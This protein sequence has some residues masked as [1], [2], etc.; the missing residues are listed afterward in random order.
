MSGLERERPVF[1][2]PSLCQSIPLILVL[3]I[4]E[5]PRASELRTSFRR[6]RTSYFHT[7]CALTHNSH[8]SFVISETLDQLTPRCNYYSWF[9]IYSFSL[10]LPLSA[11]EGNPF[12]LQ[13]ADL[14]LI[15]S[16]S[17]SRVFFLHFFVLSLDKTALLARPF[18][19]FIPGP[20]THARTHAVSRFQWGWWQ[21]ASWLAKLLARFFSVSG[22]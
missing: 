7:G 8:I 4:T 13:A 10:S 2:S 22:S 9:G 1:P 18:Y 17:R 20:A 15:L 3:T 11:D 21:L 6:R 5:T 16:G 19:S 14:A 12:A